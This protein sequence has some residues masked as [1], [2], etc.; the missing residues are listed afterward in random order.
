MFE[1][2]WWIQSTLYQSCLPFRCFI[3]YSSLFKDSNV[4]CFSGLKHCLLFSGVLNTF[5]SFRVAVHFPFSPRF[6]GLTFLFSMSFFTSF[7]FC[8]FSFPPFD[9]TTRAEFYFYFYFVKM[10]RK[11]RI[12]LPFFHLRCRVFFRWFG[13]FFFFYTYI[14]IKPDSRSIFPAQFPQVHC[15]SLELISRK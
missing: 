2:T 6:V 4:V 13:F 8:R 3:C 10:T 5:R 1:R 7:F 11:R 9:H 15:I 12:I 14:T